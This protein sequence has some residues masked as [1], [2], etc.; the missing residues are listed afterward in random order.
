VSDEAGGKS[1]CS[2]FTILSLCSLSH[3][4]VVQQDAAAEIQAAGAFPS[5][6]ISREDAWLF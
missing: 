1:A 5:V 6:T 2:D 4:A 3:L